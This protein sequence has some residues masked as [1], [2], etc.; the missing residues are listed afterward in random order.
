M[1]AQDDQR[2]A[3]SLSAV[4]AV[5][6]SIAAPS[7]SPTGPLSASTLHNSVANA[8]S[9]GNG[10]AESSAGMQTESAQA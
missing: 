4:P 6:W 8:P 2:K 3:R 5:N 10:N 1:R 9:E 7:S